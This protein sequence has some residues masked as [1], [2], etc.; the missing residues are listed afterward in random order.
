VVVVRAVF[1]FEGNDVSAHPS[2]QAAADH[3][4]PID[5]ENG[6]FDFFAED[7]TVLVS[8]TPPGGR[9]VLRPT[10]DRRPDQ[11]RQRLLGYLTHARV[12]MDPALADDPL[13]AAQAIMD[14]EWAARPFR[15][16]P[17]LDRRVNGREAPR[18][19]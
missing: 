15:W 10:S 1:I 11:L 16:F 4:E 13:A 2:L 6:E 5:V 19:G 3:V 9:V 14:A 12:G 8:E 17:L 7:G 18:V